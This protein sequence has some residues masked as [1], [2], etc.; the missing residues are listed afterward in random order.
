[1]S[2]HWGSPYGFSFRRNGSHLSTKTDCGQTW[3]PFHACCPN[4]NHCPTQNNVNCYSS[5]ADCGDLFQQQPHCANSIGN[6]LK[7]NS[8]FCCPPETV[9]FSRKQNGS[10]GCAESVEDVGEEYNLLATI[11]T[12]SCLHTR[13]SFN[14]YPITPSMISTSLATSTLPTTSTTVPPTQTSTTNTSPQDRSLQFSQ[15]NT[16]AVAGGV[17]GG[18]AGVAIVAF[19]LWFYIRRRAA[20]LRQGP[21]ASYSYGSGTPEAVVA[22]NSV[23]QELDC[24]DGAQPPRYELGAQGTTTQPEMRVTNRV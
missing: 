19:L 21:R 18:V 12:G 4:G 16:G 2:N 15:V 14:I 10:V 11:Y 17:V 7:A 13:L 9:G 23:P 22:R 5:D 8:Y 24:H 3:Q 1:M 6:L 20:S